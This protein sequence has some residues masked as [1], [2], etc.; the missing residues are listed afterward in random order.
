MSNI[1]HVNPTL[2]EMF[3]KLIVD[4]N[5]SLKIQKYIARE[6]GREKHNFLNNLVNKA[7]NA[8]RSIFDSSDYDHA[9]K[10]IKTAFEVKNIKLLKELK[11]ADEFATAMAKA[12]LKG[13]VEHNKIPLREEDFQKNK[14][15]QMNK[16]EEYLKEQ[17]QK[18]FDD[19]K[20]KTYLESEGKTQKIL[21]K[22]KITAKEPKTQKPHK[23]IKKKWH[24]TWKN[25]AEESNQKFKPTKPQTENL[26]PELQKLLSK[27]KPLP[28]KS[29]ET[30]TK[31]RKPHKKIKK[32]WHKTWK[33]WAK[34]SQKAA[35]D[36]L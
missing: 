17:M 5:K 9:L 14:K 19:A 22:I 15:T 32:K 31:T 26:K 13:C 21:D 2:V 24:K 25:W 3:D 1:Q 20:W 30:P 7:W 16:L 35:K 29:S 34:E 33:N 4:S 8:F 11:K 23:K 28:P 36:I 6:S 27:V 12:I 10:N 18:V